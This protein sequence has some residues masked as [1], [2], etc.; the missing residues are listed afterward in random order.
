MKLKKKKVKVG[1]STNHINII[2]NINNLSEEN[3]G[4]TKGSLE[5]DQ[6]EEILDFKEEGNKTVFLVE[7]KKKSGKKLASSYVGMHDLEKSHHE[8]LYNFYQKAFTQF[9]Q[10]R[11]LT[12]T[13]IN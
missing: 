12:A 13:S 8:L 3:A 9:I 6:P 10:I 7:W 4:L 1:S 11:K 5:N 2:N